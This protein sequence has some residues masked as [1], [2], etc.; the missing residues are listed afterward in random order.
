[1]TIVT[2]NA[3]LKQFRITVRLSDSELKVLKAEAQ[4]R[5]VPVGAALRLLIR[6]RRGVTNL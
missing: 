2:E 6:A 3:E 1:M 4:K 5:G